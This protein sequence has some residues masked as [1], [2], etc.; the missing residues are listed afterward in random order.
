MADVIGM[1]AIWAQM[2]SLIPKEE[3]TVERL[4]PFEC[5][6]CHG[7]NMLNGVCRDCGV[8]IQHI[9]D[10][11]EWNCG[12]TESGVASDGCRVGMARDELHTSSWG[13]GTVMNVA[14]HQRAK[15]GFAGRINFHSSMN[16]R[17]RA[18]YKVYQ[19]FDQIGQ[20]LGISKSAITEAKKMYKDISEQKLYRGN[21]RKGVKANCIAEACKKA[22][23]PRTTEEVAEAMGMSTTDISRTS[24]KMEIVEQK[25][26]FTGPA[27]IVP[28]IFND[29]ELSCTDREKSVL[30]M[31]CIRRCEE[32]SEC[33]ELMGKTPKAV[34]VVIIYN[35]LTS[36]GHPLD[37]GDFVRTQE[38]ISMA[39]FNKL[40]A[41]VKKLAH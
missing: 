31:K 16:H 22:G 34:A 7:F 30:K 17:D 8:C 29:I 40:D 37:K 1:D 3:P 38:K 33:P 5:R 41:I 39:T 2:D 13:Q 26:G 12:V 20:R 36:Q 28:R 4:D 21:I 14:Y 24:N 18:L 32:L 25:S 6:R 35:V 19:E 23:V 27:D 10:S 11:A 9:D 15:W